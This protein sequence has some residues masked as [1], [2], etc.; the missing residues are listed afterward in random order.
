MLTGIKYMTF[1]FMVAGFLAA[2]TYVATIQTLDK[3]VTKNLIELRL[4]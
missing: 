2:A 4:K 3:V 1:G